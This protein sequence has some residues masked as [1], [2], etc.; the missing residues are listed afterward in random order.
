VLHFGQVEEKE[1]VTYKVQVMWSHG[2][3]TQFAFSGKDN[4][5][6]TEREDTVAKLP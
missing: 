6:E 3:T 5:S 4:M 2:E 1:A